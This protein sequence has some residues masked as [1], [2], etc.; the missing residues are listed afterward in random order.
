MKPQNPMALPKD[1]QQYETDPALV[2]I[3]LSEHSGFDAVINNPM[4]VMTPPPKYSRV[5]PSRLEQ[6]RRLGLT[7][8]IPDT[9]QEETLSGRSINSLLLIAPLCLTWYST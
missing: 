3:T 2:A 5:E 7:L 8:T 9:T 6:P 1:E 4:R